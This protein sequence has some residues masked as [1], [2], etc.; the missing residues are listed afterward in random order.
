MNLAPIFVISLLEHVFRITVTRQ[1]LA[2]LSSVAG[3]VQCLTLSCR[4]SRRLDCSFDFV[5]PLNGSRRSRKNPSRTAFGEDAIML[6]SIHR[7]RSMG[8]VFL[9]LC[10][11]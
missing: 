11:L 9:R 4:Y 8:L 10:G 2:F 3:R 1:N 6:S 5:R 7:M